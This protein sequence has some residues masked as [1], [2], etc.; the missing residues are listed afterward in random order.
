MKLKSLPCLL[1]IFSASLHQ[2]IISQDWKQALVTP[3]FK[4]GN[5]METS[6]YCP[7]SLTCICCKILE[8]VIHANIMPHLEI[9]NILSNAQFGFRKHHMHSVKLQLIQTSHDFKLP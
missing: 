4:K 2:G 5:R 7:I 3:L 6:N 8:H 9:N 1:L